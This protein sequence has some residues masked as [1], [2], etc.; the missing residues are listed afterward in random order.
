MK[1]ARR[2]TALIF[3]LAILSC[4]AEEPKMETAKEAPAE[5]TAKV[6]KTDE[7]WK[8]ELTPEQYRILRQAGTEPANG[9]VYK[10]FKAQGE[11]NYH[12]AGCGAL[13]FSSKEKF[14]SKCGW[15]SFYDPAKA[16]NV[17]TKRDLSHGM[18]RVEV[19]CAKCD[20]HLGHVFEGEGFNTPT[21][22]RYC[23]N[24][25]GLTFVP[26]KVGAEEKKEE[27]KP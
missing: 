3:S 17:K 11:G 20:G 12:C 8:K 10:E 19:V 22:K 24:G 18:I 25:V 27:K 5:P 13:L 2:L 26:G 14:D 21:D 9:A 16:Q 4:H 1:S 6:E 15:P 7:Q 23:I